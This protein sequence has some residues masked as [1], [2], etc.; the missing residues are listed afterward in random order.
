MPYF[1]KD[2]FRAGQ[3]LS[4]GLWALGPYRKLMETYSHTGN[5]LLREQIW[6][7]LEMLQT[8]TLKIR[9]KSLL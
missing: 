5:N 1:L 9:A 7:L 4:W 2:E 8:T 6:V 3:R